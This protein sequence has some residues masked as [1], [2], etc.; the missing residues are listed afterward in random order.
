MGALPHYR[1]SHIPQG[2]RRVFEGVIFDIYQWEQE[3][4]DGSL[5]TFEMAHRADSAIVFP[6]LPDGRILLVEDTQPHRGVVLTAPCGRV[7]PGE[8][9]IDAARRELREETGYD[10]AQLVPFYTDEPASKTDSVVYVYIGK[11]CV[12]VSEPTLDP[13]E[14]IT[15]RIVTFEELI[16]LATSTEG[17]TYR[18]LPFRL[19]AFETLINKKRHEELRALFSP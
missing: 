9:P 19:R 6:I 10:A 7:E 18:G 13:G 15:P 14:R 1:K 4:F 11:S 12:K 8:L 17:L 2:A 5:A 16:K 3:L